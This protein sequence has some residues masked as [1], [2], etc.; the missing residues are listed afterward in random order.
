MAVSLINRSREKEKKKDARKT[1]FGIVGERRKGSIRGE[2]N[3]SVIGLRGHF[4]DELLCV[5]LVSL[6]ASL[7]NQSL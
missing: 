7:P 4:L 3:L 1:D 2:I 6:S 5:R